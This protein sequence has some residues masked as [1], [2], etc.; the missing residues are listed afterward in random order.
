MEIQVRKMEDVDHKM[1]SQK[2]L[3]QAVK[4]RIEISNGCLSKGGDVMEH[5]DE[6]FSVL[7]M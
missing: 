4:K 1:K 7:S 5:G 6:L 2:L 3:P